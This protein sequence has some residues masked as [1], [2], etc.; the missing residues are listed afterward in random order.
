MSFEPRDGLR[1]TNARIA[2]IARDLDAGEG[3]TFEFLCECTG[4][5]CTE[6]VLLSLTE[7]FE[8]TRQGRRVLATG[9]SA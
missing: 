2:A 3:S 4:K 9:H 5:E 8:L 7:Y 1:E 6:T